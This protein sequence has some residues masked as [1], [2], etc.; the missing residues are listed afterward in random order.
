MNQIAKIVRDKNN[1][2]FLKIYNKD[3]KSFVC[4]S[5]TV[6]NQTPKGKLKELSDVFSIDLGGK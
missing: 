2:V 3:M 5:I 4:F 1:D 6:W